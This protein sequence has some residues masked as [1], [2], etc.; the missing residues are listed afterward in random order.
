MDEKDK[1][2]MLEYLDE[3]I[4]HLI[5]AR[6][7]IISHEDWYCLNSQLTQVIQINNKLE[8]L[9]TMKGTIK[10]D[11]L[12]RLAESPNFTALPHSFVNPITAWY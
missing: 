6:K 3:K 9:I 10:S 5:Q 8:L 11:M 12:D 4:Q 2:I 1:K 7:E